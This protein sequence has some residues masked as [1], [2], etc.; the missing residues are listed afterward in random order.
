MNGKYVGFFS[1]HHCL[2]RGFEKD[3]EAMF[4]PG[5]N[6]GWDQLVTARLGWA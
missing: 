1:G 5:E 3:S 4:R 2:K 6:T